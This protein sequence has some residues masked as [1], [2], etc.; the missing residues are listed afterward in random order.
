MRASGSM[1]SDMPSAAATAIASRIMAANSVAI[2][3]SSSIRSV[4]APVNTET[5]LKHRLPSS[6]IHSSRRML[7]VAMVWKPAPPNTATSASTRAEGWLEGSPSTSRLPELWRTTPGVGTSAARYTTPPITRWLAMAAPMRPSPSQDLSALPASAP[8]QPSKNHQGTPFIAVT[9]EVSGPS[10]GTRS[11]TALARL[12]LFSAMI[13]TSCTPSS[14]GLSLAA[15]FTW[16]LLPPC[17][18]V[19]PSALSAAR[20]A[21]RATRLTWCPASASRAP[22]VPPMAPAPNMQMRIRESVR[23]GVWVAPSVLQSGSPRH[24]RRWSRAYTARLRRSAR[25]H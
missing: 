14:A 19:R 18:R 13:T 22:M 12:W 5:G 9:T 24:C 21:P 1:S 15:S 17:S 25:R 11:A 16:C 4:V 8:P 10:S 2:W 23:T 7:S 3:R 6:F 20:C